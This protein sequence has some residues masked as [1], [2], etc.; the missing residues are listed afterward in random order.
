VAPDGSSL[1]VTEGQLRA[2][3]HRRRS[4]P[5][6]LPVASRLRVKPALPWAGFTRADF[7]P[8]PFAGGRTVSLRFDLMPTAWRFRAGHRIR[9]SLAGA[10]QGSFE[11]SPAFFSGSGDGAGHPGTAVFWHLHRGRG[12]SV[13]I[14]PWI[15]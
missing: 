4:A 11:Q 8:A 6:S 15:P 7:D 9:L 10:D 3:Y 5:D 13:L 12:Q 14:L 2:N 1:L